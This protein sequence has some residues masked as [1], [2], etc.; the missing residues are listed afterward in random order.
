MKFSQVL[1]TLLALWVTKK[2][3]SHA[4]QSHANGIYWK[5]RKLNAETIQSLKFQKQEYGKEKKRSARPQKDA[6]APR[7]NNLRSWVQE[8]L[9]WGQTSWEENGKKIGYSFILPHVPPQNNDPE[10]AAQ[11]PRDSELN[12]RLV[13]T[14][15]V[16][17][18]SLDEISLKG[19]R[20]RNVYSIRWVNELKLKEQQQTSTLLLCSAMFAN[21]E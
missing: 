1:Q 7:A 21:H 18:M 12:W 4:P 19:E 10:P 20:K 11:D 9:W 17:P 8:L 13:S 15:K 6:R 2:L 5:K 14:E 16:H 3:M